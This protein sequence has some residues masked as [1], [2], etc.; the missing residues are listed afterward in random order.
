MPDVKI[1]ALPAA[2]S[3]NSVDELAAN[4]AGTTRKVTLEQAHDVYVL[5]RDASTVTINNSNA[6]T[7]LYSVRIP[8]RALGTNRV[9]LTK[10]W[11]EYR[12]TAGTAQTVA[13]RVGYSTT[14]IYYDLSAA[15][16]VSSSSRPMY[17]EFYLANRGATNAQVLGGTITFGSGG[18][19]TG[20]GDLATDEIVS[21]T[22]IRGLSAIDST[23]AATF[24]VFAR[25]SAASTLVSFNKWYAYTELV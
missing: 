8:A 20:E 6:T 18:A 14:T 21:N 23:S 19:T 4:Q 5:G 1:S 24:E 2:S 11:G 7:S 10:L 22:P 15:P 16:A 17:M 13:I 3:G 9:A 25:L 12:H